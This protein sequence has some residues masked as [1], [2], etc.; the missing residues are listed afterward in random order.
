[1]YKTLT[2]LTLLTFATVLLTGCQQ[3]ETKENLTQTFI[4]KKYSYSME[5]PKTW[6]AI[7][8]YGESFTL[9]LYD[10]LEEVGPN[11]P[12]AF[13]EEDKNQYYLSI[14]VFSDQNTKRETGQSWFDFYDKMRLQGH[15][16]T[17]QKLDDNTTE[18]TLFGKS[19]QTCGLVK[20]GKTN[21]SLSFENKCFDNKND[22]EF[23]KQTCRLIEHKNQLYS[24]CYNNENNIHSNI[25]KSIKF[26]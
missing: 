18:V 12:T 9:N 16:Y 26:E 4:N 21:E 20:I 5:L 13:D 6:G 14:E 7:Q 24:F 23:Y 1:M 11:L 10:D 8:P 15:T 17:K 25:I 3:K 22:V 2:S 19:K